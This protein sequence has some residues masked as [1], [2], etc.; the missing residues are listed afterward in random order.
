LQAPAVGEIV[1]DLYRGTE[2]F[3]DVRSFDV[4]RFAP[5]DPAEQDRG[6]LAEV[7]II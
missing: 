2:P 5:A 1:R 4:D 7:H 6:L 3:T